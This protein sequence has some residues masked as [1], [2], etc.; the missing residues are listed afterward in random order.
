MKAQNNK[1]VAVA[2]ALAAAFAFGPAGNAFAAQATRAVGGTVTDSSAGNANG[3]GLPQIQQQ[4][5]VPYVSGGVGQD[6]STALKRARSHWPLSMQFI[7]PGSD[8]L[9]DVHVRIVDAHNNEVLQADSLG[10]FM[11]VKLRPGRYTVHATYKDRDQTKTVSIA[12][13][14]S[15][16]AAFYW[17]VE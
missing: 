14:G 13:K 7:G 1:H 4:G 11:L 15:T 3:G 16:Q 2:A 5:D 8:F 17:N 9:A 12:S 6:E 10:P